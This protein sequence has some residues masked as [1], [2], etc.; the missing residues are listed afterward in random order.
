MSST[1]NAENYTSA[2]LKE[3]PGHPGYFIART[4]RCVVSVKTGVLQKL[5]IGVDKDG[6]KQSSLVRA[7]G[8][9]YLYKLH[10]LVAKTYLP[11]RPSNLHEVRHLNG[12]KHDNHYKNLAWGTRKDNADDRHRHGRTARGQRQGASKLTEFKVRSIRALL[13][14]GKSQHAVAKK[15]KIC[16]ATVSEIHTKKIWSWL[17]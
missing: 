6:Y 1:R 12:K 3:I 14:S 2:T 5:A 8:S 7:N 15:F 4:G 17:K 9:S 16:Q 10:A 11:P 13:A